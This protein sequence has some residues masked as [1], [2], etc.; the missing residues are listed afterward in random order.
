MTVWLGTD[1]GFGAAEARAVFS[2]AEFLEVGVWQAQFWG[3]GVGFLT[4]FEGVRGCG[5]EGKM[6]SV[7]GRVVGREDGG[8]E[9]VG[10]DFGLLKRFGGGGRGDG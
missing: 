3:A 4:A 10:L 9:T 7:E 6:K 1:A 5:L 2:G 8:A